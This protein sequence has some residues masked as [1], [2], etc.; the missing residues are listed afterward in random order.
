MPLHLRADAAEIPAHP[1]RLD[2]LP[3]LERRKVDFP[4]AL[5]QAER[6]Q[7][8]SVEVEP[9]RLGGTPGGDGPPVADLVEHAVVAGEDHAVSG[10]LHERGH[11]R[12]RQ[13]FL[14]RTRALPDDA[15]ELQRHGKYACCHHRHL[16]ITNQ[17]KRL[18]AASFI[19]KHS[20]CRSAESFDARSLYWSAMRK[21][22]PGAGESML[23]NR[24][25][26]ENL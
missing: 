22:A 10:Q 23:R 14:A 3:G 15:V 4:D 18:G 5:V 9:R 2:G 20:T 11:A 8:A 19:L 13:R 26:M 6:A 1:R 17:P 25:G 24:Q 7:G 16:P 21:V 12:E